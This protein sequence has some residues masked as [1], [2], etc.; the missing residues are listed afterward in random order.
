MRLSKR[1]SFYVFPMTSAPFVLIKRSHINVLLFHRIQRECIRNQ[2]LTRDVSQKLLLDS[3]STDSIQF[4][5]FLVKRLSITLP[6]DQELRKLRDDNLKFCPFYSFMFA[7]NC[8]HT[9][10][11]Y[12]SDNSIAVKFDVFLTLTSYYKCNYIL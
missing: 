10:H 5:S 9:I 11:V 1:L 3:K 7:N 12:V 6:F 2:R 8:I 4:D